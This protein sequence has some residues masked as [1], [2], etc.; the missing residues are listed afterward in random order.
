MK[1][2]RYLYEHYLY[3]YDNRF[4]VTF[5]LTVAAFNL[6]IIL[7]E[8]GL[9]SM[10]VS[11]SG[12]SII[13]FI[14]FFISIF[15][16]KKPKI[17]NSSNGSQDSGEDTIFSG[18]VNECQLKNEKKT[19]IMRKRHVSNIV[20]LIE[21]KSNERGFKGIILT[22][23][24][25]AGKSILINLLENDLK[26]KNYSVSIVR[27]FN[28]F[29]SENLNKQIVF[30]DQFE[31]ALDK[32][33]FLK[34][35]KENSGNCVFVFVFPQNYMSSMKY[36]FLSNELES[37]L[38]TIY[39]L[40]LNNEDISDYECKIAESCSVETE[41]INKYIVSELINETYN[42]DNEK[43]NEEC[44]MLCDELIR[45]I[46]GEKPLIELE[47]LGYLLNTD[48]LDKEKINS[49]SSFIYV[50]LDEWANRF[51]NKET[52]YCIL[53]LMSEFKKFSF[54]QIMMATFE[55]EKYYTLKT[56]DEEAGLLL[57][58]LKDNTFFNIDSNKK[59]C[60]AK[61]QYISNEFRKYCSNKKVSENMQQYINYI[62]N[63]SDNN[64]E[65]K[66]HYNKIKKNH[67]KYYSKHIGI[68]LMI[69]IMYIG[70]IFFNLLKF[71]EPTEV[72]WQLLLNSLI[73]LPS[74]Y[75]IY[76][77]CK[78]FF[79]I[80]NNFMVKFIYVIG[81]S[82]VVLSYIFVDTWGICFGSEIFLLAL[83]IFIFYMTLDKKNKI[84]SRIF[85]NDSIVFGCIGL[86]V[87][88]LG[89]MYFNLFPNLD[90]KGQ[91]SFWLIFCKYSYYALFFIYAMLSVINHIKCSYIFGRIGVFNIVR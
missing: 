78:R 58:A 19:I 55:K 75:Y 15:K 1:V 52:A 76:N 23:D 21:N 11:I 35:I 42:N 30:L 47:L 50:T 64:T 38:D 46:K 81:P 2:K 5:F 32:N 6:S 25:G 70:I 53:S 40:S 80:L 65:S 16:I 73:S 90:L 56:E 85:L 18:V 62:V 66:E 44:K 7:Y 88:S 71:K 87:I 79:I 48:R 72:H 67:S 41:Y 26:E 39:V 3:E 91:S 29:N 13:A 4:I 31:D 34:K 57:K 51:S 22:G 20:S 83:S 9:F 24:S 61:H 17:Y 89:I 12:I 27:N 54:E 86:V 43:I 82:L 74:I 84:N 68:H 59:T 49:S 33:N 10:V 69:I 45:V 36:L 14:P 8:K 28:S 60:I 63:C 77:Y 37:V